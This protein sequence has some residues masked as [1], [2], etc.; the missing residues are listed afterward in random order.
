MDDMDMSQFLDV[1]CDV[2]DEPIQN[3]TEDDIVLLDEDKP[4]TPKNGKRVNS[5]GAKPPAKRAKP[6][7]GKRQVVAQPVKKVVL[8]QQAQGILNNSNLTV[9]KVG[10]G[11][12]MAKIAPKRVA[13]APSPMNPI[14]WKYR[15]LTENLYNGD[16]R[17]ADLL[18]DYDPEQCM[19]KEPA[20]GELACG[21]G[22]INRSTF[23]ECDK[24]LCKFGE[25]CGNQKIQRRQY[26][27]GLERFMTQKKGWGV[28]ARQAISGG[29]LILE[30]MGEMCSSS[31]FEKRMVT[32]YKGDT[33]HYCLAIDGKTVIDAQRAG[34]ECRF[35]NHS[36]DP[37]CEMEK[38]NVNG[39]YRMAV[40][41][42]RDI[43]PS[44]EIT[45]DY[46]FSLFDSNEGQECKCGAA[47][48]R[49]IIGGKG[50]DFL[51]T[52]NDDGLPANSPSRKVSVATDPAGQVTADEKW[53]KAKVPEEDMAW[54]VKNAPKMQQL[55]AKT[56]KCTVCNECL[57]FKVSGQIQRHP[58]LGVIL[59][60]KCRKNYGK[61]GWDRDPDGNDE[62]CRWCSQGGQ[63]YLCDFCPKAFCNN[64]LKWNLGRKYVKSIEEEEKWKC[65]V[66]NPSSIRTQ[67]ADYW[68][69]HQYIKLKA[70]KAAKKPPVKVSSAKNSPVAT[71]SVRKVPVNG[72]PVPGIKPIITNGGTAPQ[73]VVRNGIK[74]VVKKGG[75]SAPVRL[76]PAAIRPTTNGGGAPYKKHY[77]DSMLLE[78]DR[79]SNKL[80]SMIND[81]RKS[82]YTNKD[83]ENK[84]VIL[85]TMKIREAL[86]ASTVNLKN[87]DAKIV[88]IFK[89]NMVEGTDIDLIDPTAAAQDDEVE[90]IESVPDLPPPLDDD[91]EEA[92]EGDGAKAEGSKEEGIHDMSVD[93]LEVNGVADE[94]EEK[95]SLPES[96]KETESKDKQDDEKIVE[97]SIS[98]EVDKIEDDEDMDDSNKENENNDPLDTSSVSDA[99]VDDE[100]KNDKEESS[101]PLPHVEDKDQTEDPLDN[102]QDA[103]VDNAD[104]NGVEESNENVEESDIKEDTSEKLLEEDVKEETV[105]K[106]ENYG[107]D[108][109]KEEE[110][111]NHAKDE[112]SESTGTKTENEELCELS[113]ESTECEEDKEQDVGSKNVCKEPLETMNGVTLGQKLSS[114]PEA[115]DSSLTA[116][117]KTNEENLKTIE[118]SIAEMESMAGSE[119]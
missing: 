65:L 100:D 72:R 40:F 71:A 55:E 83:R 116:K 36:C 14:T 21:E 51:I 61:G 111:E 10:N 98:E 101:S 60:N 45:Y 91:D 79:A 28:R 81:L 114:S 102:D 73:Y 112:S 76:V 108:E 47:Q 6:A 11:R 104:T 105:V 27:P 1:A 99:Q 34:S 49:G 59:C 78:A 26:A 54:I 15:Q 4:P 56:I 74:Y 97:D 75:T 94:D 88:D 43:L 89:T 93:E 66:C 12:P 86:A 84:T 24:E 117:M 107:T 52:V 119:S 16:I 25:N 109:T 33:H 68:G 23:A 7:P 118:S 69:I 42:K 8:S 57:N 63:I 2:G 85:A 44:E 110:E 29:T 46:N 30:Y 22:C 18:K 13:P 92:K 53:F 37:N 35:V 67:R 70:S 20:E 48:C 50:K 38:W 96:K 115:E 39:L 90:K 32:R 3:L 17:K 9:K 87:A 103:D 58:E 113:L 31:E 5:G 41:A 77:V 19:C 106:E 62:F 95:S 80:R 64:C 82:W